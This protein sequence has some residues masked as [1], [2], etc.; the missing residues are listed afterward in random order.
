M[1]MKAKI[2]PVMAVAMSVGVSVA[3]MRPASPVMD[4]AVTGDYVEARTCSVFAGACHY[5]GELVTT[6]KDAVMA[7]SFAG[8]SFHGVDLTGV[9]AMAAVTSEENLGETSAADRKSELAVDSRATP[10]QVA[11][12]ADLL[13]AKGVLSNVVA[14]RRTPV[15]FTHGDQGYIVRAEGFGAMDVLYRPDN[16]CCVQPNLV[17]YEPMTTL[18][19]RK[20]GFTQEA[21]F[22]GKRWDPWVRRG[23][24]SA[25]YGKF[26]F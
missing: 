21:S 16:S 13:R 6:G 5:N 8:G 9:K 4:G 14:V 19:H 23:E 12:V 2:L 10:E 17:W 18:E 1:N 3:A 26:T 15:T 22:E 7:W 11:A 24:D 20:V 25:F